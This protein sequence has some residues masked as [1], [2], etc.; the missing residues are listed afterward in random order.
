MLLVCTAFAQSSL[1][2]KIVNKADNKPL[3][4]ATIVLLDQDS[5][6]KYFTRANEDGNFSFKQLKNASYTMIITYPKFELISRKVELNQNLPLGT[7]ALNSQAH[8]IEEVVVTHRLPI[9]VK[10]DTIEYNAA[11][12][13]TEKNA[14][15]EDLLRRLPGL[16]VSADGAITAHGKSVS[17]VLIDGEEFFGYDPKIAIRN[18]RADAVDKVQVYERKSEEAELTG[19]DDGQRIQTVNVVLKEE[20]RK[21][22]FGNV[23]GH[24]GTEEL[25]TANLFAAK[26]NRTERIGITANTNNMGASSGGREGSLRMNSQITGEP[27]NTSVGANYN[28]QFFNKKLNVI[29]NY[30]FNDGSN[31]NE[32]SSYN[33]EILSSSQI[34]E[35]NSTSRNSNTNQGHNFRSEFKWKVDSTS[36][37]DVQISAN[38]SK[39]TSGTQSE[40]Y[41]TD[42]ALDSI[43]TFRNKNSSIGNSLS[44]DIRLNYRKRL[45]KR[46][47]S[48]NIH[49]NN[50]YNDS[51]QE[52][53]VDQ[54]TYFHLND[55]TVNIDQNRVSDNNR[56]NFSTQVHFSDRIAQKINYSLGYNFSKNIS[57]S[58]LDAYDLNAGTTIVDIDYSQN[59]KTDNTN[60]TIVGN[61]NYFTEKVSLNLSNRTNYRNQQLED[62]Y[63]NIDLSRDFWDNDLNFSANYRI[64]NRKNLNVSYQNNYDVPSFGQ[65]QPLQPQTNPFFIQ[66]GNPDLIKATNNSFRVNYNT[67]SLLRGTS[68]NINSGISLKSDPIVNKRTIDS[69]SVT[70]STYV[71]VLGKSSWNANLNAN[72]NKPIFDKRIQMNISSGANYNNGFSYIRFNESGSN[73][74]NGQY[75]LNNSQNAN[76]NTGIGFNEQDSKGLDFD[77]QWRLRVNNQ[78]N[79][80]QENLNYTNFGMSGNAYLRYFLP[81]QFNITT[82]VV[83]DLDGPTKLYDK[84]IQQFYANVELSKKL[85]KSQSLVASLKVYDIFNSFNNINR[86]VSE[87]NFSESR[88]LILTRYA[89]F[90]LKWDFNKNLGKKKED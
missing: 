21:G 39:N 55:S 36:N 64:S 41:V 61:L 29:S 70:T 80:I 72:Y 28:N 4:H 3:T 44:N 74:P 37:L 53:L 59:Q 23:E 2:G 60:Q 85:L 12:F 10:G 68:W 42:E 87:T 75:E 47:T 38:K 8:L 30:N 82:N 7:I 31:R 81:K 90:G 69:A 62:S 18:V 56:N 77:F 25:Y 27:Q 9:Q 71:N 50:S 24:I 48:I 83:Y 40:S 45:N 43:R 51:D 17:K 34:Q 14:K 5:I 33:K 1:S 11:S 65:L 32:R 19:I 73:N 13:E 26:F 46:G 79:S 67:M 66:E 89:L 76:F 35:T 57:T 16:T 20:A 78:R 6:M 63:R 58:K 52:N 86:S 22:I 88:Q 54:Y 84:S 49:L 15:L